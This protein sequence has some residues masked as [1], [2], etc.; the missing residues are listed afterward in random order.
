MHQVACILHALALLLPK[1]APQILAVA[2][3]GQ[4]LGQLVELFGRDEAVASGNFFGAGTFVG[5]SGYVAGIPPVTFTGMSV[6]IP[7]SPVTLDRNT[8]PNV[9]I[10]RLVDFYSLTNMSL[11]SL[12]SDLLLHAAAARPKRSRTPSHTAASGGFSTQISLTP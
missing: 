5:I 11:N 9:L 10:R 6:T 1:Q 12:F 2:V 3:L 4:R 7:E 8:P